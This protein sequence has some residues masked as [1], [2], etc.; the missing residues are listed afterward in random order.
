MLA[1]FKYL[2]VSVVWLL[3][4]V[5]PS[6]AFASTAEAGGHSPL[7]PALNAIL[8]AGGVA[9]ACAALFKH[10]DQPEVLG[11]LVAGMI[12]GTVIHYGDGT[13]VGSTF[14]LVR[15][16]QG[17][18]TLAS[19]GALQLLF[20]A[21]LHESVEEML[22][23]GLLAIAVATVGVIAPLLGIAAYGMYV[24]DLH[25]VQAL[26][27]GGVA[28]ATSVS[29]TAQILKSLRLDKHPAF[30]LLMAAAVADDVMGLVVLAVCVGAARMVLSGGEFELLSIAITLG[31]AVAFIVLG[32]AIGRRVV[33]FYYH[34]VAPRMKN[35]GRVTMSGF[36]I[37]VAFGALAEL[38]GLHFIIGAFVG[39]IVL[40][41]A[42]FEHLETEEHEHVVGMERLKNVVDANGIFFG[43]LF[44]VWVGSQTGFQIFFEGEA[45]MHGIA[46]T[47]IAILG[48]VVSGVVVKIAG[49][50][51]D[52]DPLFVGI[53]MIP[54]GEVG[55]VFASIGAATIFL[56][57]EGVLNSALMGSALIMITLTTLIAAPLIKARA[58]SV[59]MHDVVMRVVQ[60]H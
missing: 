34:S 12:V 15:D 44:F 47:L 28:T 38:A 13:S 48:K 59:G 35:H 2:Q 7:V 55:S 40:E 23:V 26:F 54:R 56:G 31:K 30:R 29:V 3:A 33:R 60:T 19:W 37:Q 51:D 24:M 22:E 11:Y 8:I 41:S 39:G 16:H 52:I 14:A 17:F 53:G 6:V 4:G 36:L 1:K 42:M 43:A 9:L 32:V 57:G 46:L 45:L 25:W 18:V 50:G 49:R 27:L 5:I 21:G 58:L 20:S 10:F